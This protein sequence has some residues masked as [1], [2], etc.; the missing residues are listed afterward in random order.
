M[1][2]KFFCSLFEGDSL[3]GTRLG[4]GITGGDFWP[5]VSGCR[6]LYRAVLPDSI[7]E[8]TIIYVADCDDTILN[9]SPN[10]SHQPST[11]YLY[12]LRSVNSCGTEEKSLSASRKISFDQSGNNITQENNCITMLRARQTGPSL[13][14]LRWYYCA[15][16]RQGGCSSFNVYSDHASGR[17]AY[18]QAIAVVPCFGQGYY[19]LPVSASLP[20]QYIYTIRAVSENA[21]E[22]PDFNKVSIQISEL[23]PDTVCVL[24]AEQV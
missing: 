2:A 19:S 1:E 8:K 21:I 11:D 17:I 24:I 5:R 12:V 22:T 14:E 15:L 16:G 7:D 4:M 3:N 18:S 10:M 9:V 23:V 6:N 20:G 13:V